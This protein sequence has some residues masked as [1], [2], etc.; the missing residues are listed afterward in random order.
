MNN[1][2][3]QPRLKQS[4]HRKQTSAIRMSDLILPALAT[5]LCLAITVFI[6]LALNIIKETN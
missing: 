5:S 4:K 2:A 6:V 1:Q 3:R